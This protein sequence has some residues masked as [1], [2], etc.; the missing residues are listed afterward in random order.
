VNS[1]NYY[2]ELIQPKPIIPVPHWTEATAARDCNTCGRDIWIG[3]RCVM[4]GPTI[5][6]R[7]C[8]PS[9]CKHEDTGVI[10]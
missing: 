6:C 8:G 10:V 4:S 2:D 5:H 7:L 3:E 1:H 9:L